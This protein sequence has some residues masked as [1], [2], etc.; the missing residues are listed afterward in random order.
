MLSREYNRKIAI[1]VKTFVSDGFGGQIASDVLVKSVWSK[2]QTN[3]GSKFINFG[4]SDFKNPAIFSVRGRKNKIVYTEK[5][6]VKYKG[7]EYYIKG[8]ENRL[9]EDMELNLYCDSN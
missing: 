8:I 7:Q 5:H 2:I 3:A 1:Y 6:F 4:L 9:A